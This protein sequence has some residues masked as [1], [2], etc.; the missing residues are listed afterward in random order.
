M[1]NIK[2]VTLE[3]SL[4]PFKSTDTAVIE[5]VC[6][7]AFM[8]WK[9]L[10]DNA[11][12]VG[13]MLWTADGS[14]LLDYRGNLDDTFEWAHFLGGANVKMDWDRKNDPDGIGLHTRNYPYM[15]NAP[16]YTYRDL[17]NIVS[18]IKEVGTRI[19]GKPIFVGTTFDPGP[20][21][22]VSDFKYNRHNE[23]CEGGSMGKK[24]MV[25]CYGVLNG[26]DVTYA[27]Y[28]NGIPDGT[29]FG[30]FLG[31]QSEIFLSDMG[32]DF[33][34]LS[35]GFGFGTETWGVSGALFDGKAFYDE[36]LDD[37]REKI[38]NFWKLFYKECH[39]PVQ[40]R[41][42]NLTVGA[43][44]ASDGVDHGMIYELNPELLPPPN[45]PWA[46]LDGNFG[47]EL[48]GYM[49]R[50]AELPNED[51]LFRF[52]VH[53][54][55]WINSPWID[56]YEGQ[57][58]DIYLPTA[59]SRIDK[60]GKTVVANHINFLSIDDSYGEMPDRCPNE[61]IPYIL[62][63]YVNAPDDAAPFVWV[64][65][66]SEYNNMTSGRLEKSFFEDW[67]FIAALNHGFPVN[68]VVSTDN[69]IKLSKDKPETFKG[70]VLVTPMPSEGAAVCDALCDFVREGG[71]IMVYG[72]LKGADE[73]ILNLLNIARDEEIFGDFTVTDYTDISG[74]LLDDEV[75]NEISYN[76]I[77]TDGGLSAVIKNEDD[78]TKVLATA[79]QGDKTRVLALAHRVSE[80]TAIWCRG[81]DCSRKPVD[82]NDAAKK[83]DTVHYDSFP[84]E[85]LM[86][87]AAKYVGYNFR[88]EK[89]NRYSPEPVILMHRSN[90]AVWFNG[91]C[92]DTTVGIT[93]NTP[94]GAPLMLANECVV[95][96][97]SATYHM[98]RA[99]RHECRV[100]VTNGKKGVVHA[101]DNIATAYKI[102]RRMI[103]E[104]LED[105]TV[106]VIP[107]SDPEK[108]FFLLNSN[109]P[110]FVSQ[111]PFTYELVDSVFGK[112]YKL[113]GI[114][115][116]LLI[117][118][119]M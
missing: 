13:V 51:Y 6:E 99:W 56:R 2:R 5:K 101:K 41:G 108:T 12:E 11:L 103:V 110:H 53:D 26:D 113:T 102:K 8:Q 43:D 55:W 70:R 30:T 3:V 83:D 23:I 50:A 79:T 44:F 73:R 68:S 74:E 29:P 7:K 28:P 112:V 117:S 115:G 119:K 67:Y 49:S 104:G 33:I 58:H 59:T 109:F 34:W 100:F 25:C 22:A 14:E 52:Y 63:S 88:F 96:G 39:Y 93:L 31:K 81:C 107:Y 45:S 92:P 38:A 69:F 75:V 114:T 97:D 15:D 89:L 17:K 87:K 116:K 84:A 77:F 105:A 10:L 98:P 61:V 48:A 24:S 9:N 36:K 65:P 54:I 18:I 78:S 72:S 27:A 118:E 86:R 62:N 106:Y 94:L 32:F 47:L 95:D 80:G 66:F 91:Y 37:C 46:A 21:F 90:G 57:P 1:N 85:T 40:T 20:E 82:D 60:D 71:N 35:N 19:T 42:T 111:T 76:G 16:E 64:Y 4:K